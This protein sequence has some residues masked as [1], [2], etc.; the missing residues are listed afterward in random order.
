MIASKTEA[1]VRIDSLAFPHFKHRVVDEFL[2][3]T[4]AESHILK[5]FCEGAKY[6]M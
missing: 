5:E 2:N 3:D 1:F 6:R 4:G